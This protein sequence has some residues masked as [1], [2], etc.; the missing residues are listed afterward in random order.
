MEHNSNAKRIR[1]EEASFD[2]ESSRKRCVEQNPTVFRSH[3][4]VFFNVDVV[5]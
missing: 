2:L 3:I 1:P 4:R 5:K